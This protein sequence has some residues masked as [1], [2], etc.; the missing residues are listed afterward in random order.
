MIDLIPDSNSNQPNNYR[1]DLVQL[2]ADALNSYF[3]LRASDNSEHR[4]DF[5]TKLYDLC[6]AVADI[7][8][9]RK[10]FTDPEVPA[11]D[12]ATYVFERVVI[13]KQLELL[14]KGEYD[15]FP[16][17]HYI[18]LSMKRYLI[19]PEL[20]GRMLLS[21]E[22]FGKLA[23]ELDYTDNP[24][25]LIIHKSIAKTVFNDLC[26]I[27]T[28]E[29]ISR[30]YPIARESIIN[31]IP[32]RN[33]KIPEIKD[34]VL[35]YTTIVRKRF[36]NASKIFSHDVKDSNI[37]RILHTCLSSSFFLTMLLESDII[38]NPLLYSLD[39]ESIMRLIETSGGTVVKIPVKEKLNS[40]LVSMNIATD[41]VMNGTDFV[42]AMTR[43]KA[44]SHIKCTTNPSLFRLVEL[45][46]LAIDLERN[47]KYSEATFDT[48]S[49]TAKLAAD[50][51]QTLSE[52]G[53]TDAV[54]IDKFLQLSGHIS[55]IT[56]NIIKLQTFIRRQA[57]LRK[58]EELLQN[59]IPLS[60]ADNNESQNENP[61]E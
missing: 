5:F 49:A 38:E 43:V 58:R 8:K 4:A 35:V 60:E 20:S 30:L 3:R 48:L 17:Q 22:E 37:S 25:T 24:D 12:C 55:K 53:S 9:D 61:E 10:P 33:I 18:R 52:K 56:E 21:D 19:N 44:E 26:I 31:R 14:P 13:S 7:S 6:F 57:E 2:E 42:E 59:P 1:Y 41:M 39:I 15:K 47:D 28:P 45:A 50:Y 32:P 29:E 27:Y 46:L 54:T 36:R 51:T 16:L 11:Q 23:S 34:F 40:L